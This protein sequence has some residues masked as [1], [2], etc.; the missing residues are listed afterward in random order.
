MEERRRY[1]IPSRRFEEV[2]VEKEE[3]PTLY[4]F[5]NIWNP[6]EYEKRVLVFKYGKRIEMVEYSPEAIL[7]ENPSWSYNSGK[8]FSSYIVTRSWE[9]SEIY[10]IYE[11]YDE[12]GESTYA[13]GKRDTHA[14]V[15]VYQVIDRSGNLMREPVFVEYSNVKVAENILPALLNPEWGWSFAR[16]DFFYDEKDSDVKAVLEGWYDC[17]TV[18]ERR[19]YWARHKD[20]VELWRVSKGLVDVIGKIGGHH[21]NPRYRGVGW[22]EYGEG[23]G[24]TYSIRGFCLTADNLYVVGW[25]WYSPGGFGTD[26]SSRT[27]YFLVDLSNRKLSLWDIITRDGET[28]PYAFIYVGDD[29]SVYVVLRYESRSFHGPIVRVKN[30][31]VDFV[32]DAYKQDLPDDI[33]DFTKHQ[34]IGD[35]M[36]MIYGDSRSRGRFW[37]LVD[38]KRAKWKIYDS[39]EKMKR[40]SSSYSLQVRHFARWLELRDHVNQY[41]HSGAVFDI[42]YQPFLQ[43]LPIV[44]YW[45]HEDW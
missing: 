32:F 14:H 13:E 27:D 23:S 34:Y 41:I 26:N 22:P 36:F 29:A 38:A 43:K 1:W 7:E 12:E 44:A 20:A 45:P 37:M 33:V 17:A 2:I 10:D 16:G 8:K 9:D 3:P 40:D 11:E 35:G 28:H 31:N 30:M 21:C 5:A 39:I 25:S 19:N 24:E 42:V 6:P 15:Y 4:C 18:E